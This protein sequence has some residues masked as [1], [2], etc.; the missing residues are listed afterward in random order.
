MRN[1]NS[2]HPSKN[3]EKLQLDW[4][5]AVLVNSQQ[6]DTN[7]AAKKRLSCKFAVLYIV[8]C[9]CSVAKKFKKNKQLVKAVNK[10]K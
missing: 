2:T 8:H 10:S 4:I 3:T 1:K 5:N 6:P 7:S 9:G